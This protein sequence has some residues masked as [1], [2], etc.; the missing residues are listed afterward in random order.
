MMLNNILYRMFS[1]QNAKRPPRMLQ[2]TPDGRPQSSPNTLS[3]TATDVLLLLLPLNSSRPCIIP[4]RDPKWTRRSGPKLY[5]ERGACLCSKVL[6]SHHSSDGRPVSP[7]QRFPS[8]NKSSEIRAPT[9]LRITHDG[10]RNPFRPRSALPRPRLSPPVPHHI[11]STPLYTYIHYKSSLHHVTR[12]I[13]LAGHAGLPH[14]CN[15]IYVEMH[16][17]AHGTAR[18]RRGNKS[19]S[20]FSGHSYSKSKSTMTT[21]TLVV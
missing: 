19:I 6:I 18:L 20:A 4:Y 7:R 8:I 17:R 16:A 13:H 10:Q 1:E 14:L 15:N 2:H 12:V 5:E 11:V 3:C 21:Q 9:F